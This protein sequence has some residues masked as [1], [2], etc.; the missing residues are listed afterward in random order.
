[1]LVLQVFCHYGIKIAQIVLSRFA[2]AACLMFL[3]QQLCAKKSLDVHRLSFSCIWKVSSPALHEKKPHLSPTCAE[4]ALC[5]NFFRVGRWILETMKNL[6]FLVLIWRRTLGVL[7]GG[8]HPVLM[9]GLQQVVA[10]PMDRLKCLDPMFSP[11]PRC[12]GGNR[13]AWC[14]KVAMPAPLV[15]LMS[16]RC[17]FAA[18]CKSCKLTCSIYFAFSKCVPVS[19]RP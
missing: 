19:F 14:K 10:Y 16:S 17:S 8:R 11:N 9:S 6:M 7:Y 3:Y 4:P 13:M 18:F 15:K 2:A 12:F 1:M 5:G